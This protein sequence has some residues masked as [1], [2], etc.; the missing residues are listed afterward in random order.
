MGARKF[1]FKVNSWILTRSFWLS[2]IDDQLYRLFFVHLRKNSVEKKTQ[3]LAESRKLN[4]IFQK[5][6][7]TSHQF[8]LIKT[9]KSPNFFPKKLNKNS[10][11][12]G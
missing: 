2:K 5:L 3:Y 8:Y 1:D 10:E 11:I 9:Q 6:N 7:Q 4:Q 12:S